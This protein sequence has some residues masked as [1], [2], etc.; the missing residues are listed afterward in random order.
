MS[1]IAISVKNL[2]KRYRIDLAEA[3]AATW[4]E[5]LKGTMASPFRYLRRTLRQPT[6]DE[7]LWALRDIS[8]DVKQG[9]VVG[10]IGRNGAGKSTL[11]KILSRITDPTSG[12]A[13]ISGRMGA[14]L[15][16]GTGFHP[17]L[18]GRE[19]IFLSGAIL[20]MKRLEIERKL[21][22][23]VDFSGVE[24]FIDTPVK[25]YSSG[26]NVRLAFA[27]AA[28]LEPE[29]MIID[30]VLSVGDVAFQRKCLGKME[31]MAGS[32]R[33]ILFVSHVLPSIQALC[34]RAILLENGQVAM[35]GE[36]EQVIERYIKA[37]VATG[38]TILDL[39]SHP[40]RTTD[41]AVF[42][43]IRLLNRANEETLAFAIGEP[44]TF[45]LTLDLGNR[46]LKDPLIT[47]MIERRGVR[48]CNLPT[49]YMVT[50]PFTLTGHSLVRC[51][52][53][54]PY[55]APGS[56]SLSQLQIKAGSRAD[57]L[58]AIVNVLNFEILERDLFGTGRIAVDGTVLV[59]QAEWEFI[60]SPQPADSALI[61]AKGNGMIGWNG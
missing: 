42:D 3:Q 29:I 2:S 44:I 33:T 4:V 61:P 60:T 27:V 15:E 12:E 46:V 55:L 8:F 39:R 11:L 7:T 20:G 1:D 45:E 21:D 31:N 34:N 9:E 16:V 10:I 38:D 40:N 53:H 25:R 54:A 37:N 41:V 22:E 6:E 52:W 14:L 51:T 23:I 32:G 18:T 47:F 58:D 35:D 36:P 43:R 24:K 56:Y 49:H 30:E 59:P 17:E 19:N 57:R 48:I 5:A 26:M 50:D 28:H 13:I